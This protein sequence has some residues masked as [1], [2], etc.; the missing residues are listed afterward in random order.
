MLIL[1]F[2]RTDWCLF[3]LSN[4]LIPIHVHRRKLGVCENGMDLNMADHHSVSQSQMISLYTAL[5]QRSHGANLSIPL[6]WT[7][8]FGKVHFVHFICIINFLSWQ[9]GQK[10]CVYWAKWARR[11]RTWALSSIVT[12]ISTNEPNYSNECLLNLNWLFQ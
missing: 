6:P 4:W 10:K 5:Q 12:F 7:M 1:H 11:K 8:E 9:F 2:F 3:S